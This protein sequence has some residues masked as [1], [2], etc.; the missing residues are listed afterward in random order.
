MTIY[1]MCTV[2]FHRFS[3]QPQMKKILS[4]YSQ[5]HNFDR[6]EWIWISYYFQCSIV[7]NEL[8]ILWTKV[9]DYESKWKTKCKSSI[10][11]FESYTVDSRLHAPWDYPGQVTVKQSS[12]NPLNANSLCQCKSFT[13]QQQQTKNS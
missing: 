3:T 2:I 7:Y 12:L 8:M 10:S 11:D 9:K 5:N 4:A 6:S 13:R 1:L